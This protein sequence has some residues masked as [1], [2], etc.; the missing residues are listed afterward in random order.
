[1]PALYGFD[2]YS[3]GEVA[4]RVE[5]VG[6]AKAR[7]PLVQ[8][9]LLGVLAGAFIGLGALVTPW[10]SPTGRWASRHRGCSE[11]CASRSD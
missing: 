4:R 9:A 2:A 10:S 3:P 1:M 7:L 8:T 11:G 5:N 6:V